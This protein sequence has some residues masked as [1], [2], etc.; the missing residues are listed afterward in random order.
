MRVLSYFTFLSILMVVVA[1]CTVSYS[2][3]GASI[4]QK[5]KTISV[6]YFPNRAA[7]VVPT[8]SQQ[9]TDAL[10]DKFRSQTKLTMVNGVGDVDF[11]G[12]ITRYETR[13]TAITGDDKPAK[14]RL[15]IE[16]RV[17]YTNALNP[18]E[19]FETNF[20]RFQEY[21]ANEN[22]ATV[23]SQLISDII[24]LLTEDIFNKAFVNW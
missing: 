1:G 11:A 6:Q 10:R 18:K 7:I 13:S 14:N 15:T 12:E 9:F 19:N 3:T 5:L 21:G 23:E 17:R 20:S 16:V 22:L 4:D 8:L 24:D 2:F